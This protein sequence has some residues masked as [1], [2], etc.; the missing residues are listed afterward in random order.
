[1]ITRDQHVVLADWLHVGSQEPYLSI[2]SLGLRLAES[3][4]QLAQLG[5]ATPEVLEPHMSLSKPDRKTSRE[6]VAT[7]AVAAA[8]LARK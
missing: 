8:Q 4:L 2:E 3:D 5:M 6:V 7:M 1:M